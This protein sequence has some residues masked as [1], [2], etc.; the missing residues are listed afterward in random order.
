MF[1]MFWD[2]WFRA[3]L[4]APTS[5]IYQ[6]RALVRQPSG[7]TMFCEVIMLPVSVPALVIVRD[8][9]STGIGLLCHRAVEAGTFVALKVDAPDGDIRRIRARV[10]HLTAFGDQWLLGCALREPLTPED[11]AALLPGPT[12]PVG[13]DTPKSHC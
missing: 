5:S 6:R 1:A 9:T 3:R 4:P 13:A 12:P 7:R 2:R 11:L 10:V 8:I